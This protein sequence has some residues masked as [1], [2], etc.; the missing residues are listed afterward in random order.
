MFQSSVIIPANPFL[1]K[2][3][4]HSEPF[5]LQGAD[6][7]CKEVKLNIKHARV[8]E[9]II[10]SGFSVHYL[11]NRKSKPILQRVLVDDLL[12]QLG[13]FVQVPGG[14]EESAAKPVLGSGGEA[15]VRVRR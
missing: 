10:S 14:I 1:D 11:Y 15:N 5:R 7:R 9:S 8:T 3:S 6:T 2:G 13:N 12:L 4:V